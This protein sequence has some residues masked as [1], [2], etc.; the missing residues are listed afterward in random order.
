MSPVVGQARQIRPTGDCRGEGGGHWVG[1][2]GTT[3][4]P[5]SRGWEPDCGGFMKR[6]RWKEEAANVG[7]LL[8]KLGSR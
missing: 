6:G 1:G 8:W 4:L 3:F 5:E 7:H 2:P